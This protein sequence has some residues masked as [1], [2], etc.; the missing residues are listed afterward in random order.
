[1]R[2]PGGK[3]FSR[4][5][6]LVFRKEGRD[7]RA[8]ENPRLKYAHSKEE[9]LPW[10]PKESPS[11]SGTGPTKNWGARHS[12]LLTSDLIVVQLSMKLNGVHDGYRN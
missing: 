8:G 3:E 2:N 6:G 12:C 11:P 9:P 7:R 4:G 5:I 10:S 1:M